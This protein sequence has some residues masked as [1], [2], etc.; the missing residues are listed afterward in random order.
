MI[1]KGSCHCKA[2]QFELAHVPEMVTK[3][4]RSI[5]SKRGG[6]WAYYK[7][8]DVRLISDDAKATYQW[9][10]KICK[11][12]FCN[13]VPPTTKHQ[14][15]RPG[16]FDNPQIVVNAR[17]FDDFDVDGIEVQPPRPAEALLFPSLRQVAPDL[18]LHPPSMSTLECPTAK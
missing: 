5:C 7:P 6:L 11:I 15:S 10:A 13:D 9:S 16:R 12:S 4:T 2:T 18:L 14:I 8:A 1:N 17:L 3:C